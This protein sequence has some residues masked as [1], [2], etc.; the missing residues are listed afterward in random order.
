MIKRSIRPGAPLTG[1]VLLLTGLSPA[2][3]AAQVCDTEELE[4]VTRLAGEW[5]VEAEDRLP[6]LTYERTRGQARV[7]SVLAGCGVVLTYSGQRQGVDFGTAAV[8][9]LRSDGLVEMAGADSLHDGIGMSTG[10][11]DEAA[12][13][14][15]RET[16]RGTRILTTRTTIS[17]VSPHVFT[18]VRELRRSEESAWEV[19]YRARYT[20]EG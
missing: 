2:G 15:T 5:D 12:L 13:T 9:A 18:V 7:L 10:S 8:I 17:I 16:D 1:L 14:F 11:L 6:D 4:L 3:A 20:R 19:T